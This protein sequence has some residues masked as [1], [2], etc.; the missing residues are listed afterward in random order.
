MV[1]ILNLTQADYQISNSFSPQ[2]EEAIQIGPL[3]S[4]SLLQR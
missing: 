3:T 4:A 1:T 2:R